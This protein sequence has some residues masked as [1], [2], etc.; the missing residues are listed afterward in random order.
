MHKPIDPRA[1][2]RTK[3][4]LIAQIQATILPFLHGSGFSNSKTGKTL[5]LFAFES[6]KEFL[7]TRKIR[8]SISHVLEEGFQGYTEY[9]LIMDC[10]AGGLATCH[11]EELCIED[12]FKLLNFTIRFAQRH[13]KAA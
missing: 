3:R 13:Q 12:L 7:I 5:Q 9:G 11:Y 4:K 10:Y 2:A 6:K 8:G 1:I